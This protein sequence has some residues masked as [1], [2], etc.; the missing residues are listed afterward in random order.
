MN[1]TGFGIGFEI[2]YHIVIFDPNKSYR[3]I[4]TDNRDYITSIEC[5]NASGETIFAILLISKFKFLYKWCPNKDHDG[6]TIINTT[7]IWYANDDKAFE[8]LQYFI[9]N[10]KHKRKKYGFFSSSMAINHIWQTILIHWQL[11]AILLCFGSFFV[12]YTLYSLLTLKYFNLLNITLRKR[13]IS[14]LGKKIKNLASFSFFLH[15][16]ISEIWLSSLLESEM[17]SSRKVFYPSIL[18]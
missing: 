14:L 3:M 4:D 5:I 8:W 17:L 1:E 9:D 18:I 10:T 6:G 16:N 2:A 11:S 13:Y 12:P 7:N 15:F